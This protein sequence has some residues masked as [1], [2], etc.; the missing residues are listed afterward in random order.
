MIASVIGAYAYLR[1]LAWMYFD[2]PAADAVEPGRT[3]V[4]TAIGVIVPAVLVL[5]LGIIPGLITSLLEQAS[6]LTW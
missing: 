6:V 2:E 5:V 4:S 1:V 3:H